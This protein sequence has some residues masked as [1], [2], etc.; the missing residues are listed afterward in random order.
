[1]LETMNNRSSHH[2]GRHQLEL[3]LQLKQRAG[4]Q[5][6]AHH[7][8]EPS[9][10]FFLRTGLR[11]PREPLT[12]LDLTPFPSDEIKC[13][14]SIGDDPALN[15]PTAHNRPRASDATSTMYSGLAVAEVT[16][17]E[18]GADLTDKGVGCRCGSVRDGE[19]V[20]F[21]DVNL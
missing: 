11:A 10:I 18:N 4:T 20:V 3:V 21:D 8:P 5:T 16:R 6:P 19:T 12:L 17:L 13:F 2:L 1:M 9:H 14:T 7:P 15:E